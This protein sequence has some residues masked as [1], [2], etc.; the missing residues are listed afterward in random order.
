MPIFTTDLDADGIATIAWDLPGKSMNVLTF[1][2]IAEL[3][4]AIDA[5]HADPAVKGIVIT[6]A[7]PD[8]AGGMDLNVLARMKEDAGADPARGLFD[9]IMSIH[10]LLRKIERAGMDPKSLKGGKPT[11]WAAPGLSAGIGTEIGLACHRR[12]MADTPKARVGLPEIL[13]G[14]FPGAGGT[15]RL[16]RMMGV[17]AAAPFLLEG[18]MMEPKAAKSGGPDRRGRAPGRSP[19]H[20]KGLGQGRDRRR[21]R[22]AL[23]RQGLQAP[24]RRALPA[25]G[26]HDLRRRL[27]DGAWPH[28]GRL[29]GPEG[30]AL[31]DLRGRARS[32]RHSTPDRG[33]LVRPRADEPLVRRDDPLALPEQTGAGKGRR[34]PRPARPERQEARRPRRRHDGRG[35]RHRR[36]QR[37]DRGGADRPRPGRRR[38]GPRPRRGLARRRHQ[39]QARHAGEEG[40]GPRPDHRHARLRRA[41]RLR[42][43]DRGGLRG[44]GRQGRGHPPRRGAP[45]RRRDLRHQHLDAADRRA[46]QGEPRTGAV[47]RHPLLLAGREDGAGRDHPRQGHRRPRRRQG[48][49]FR[50]PDQEDPDRRQ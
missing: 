10:R 38:Q 30:D 23:G 4:A 48:A 44:P 13:L 45:A 26:L 46:G 7:K 16:V 8:F 27:G 17:M 31:G 20:R 1:E 22:Q 29:P 32:L 9:G 36:R 19:R 49:R 39:A 41:G 33:A 47:H 37:R 18:K 15:T 14:I 35:H 42:H 2:G 12:F 50:A 43:G 5:A 40:R 3:D 34:P 21:H 6:S 11:A 24:R 28:P 25:G